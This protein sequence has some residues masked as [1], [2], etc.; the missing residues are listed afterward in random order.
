MKILKRIKKLISLYRFKSANNY[1]RVDLY[2]K[3]GLK[4]GLKCQIFNN[5][6]LGSEPFLIQFGDYVK[7]TN[8]CK[9][10]THD[11]G[12]EVLRNLKWLENADKFGRI[13]VG[14]NVFFGNNCIILPG[15]TIGDN[16]VIGAGSVVTKDIPSNTVAAGVPA[17]VIKTIDE[18]YNSIKEQVDYTKDLNREQKKEYLYK[19]YKLE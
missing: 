17:R 7:V 8:G 12:I 15:V 5:C 1:K 10:I 19:K 11:G 18:Y 16:V 9:F 2:R 6:S 4:A 14:S 13:K 3:K